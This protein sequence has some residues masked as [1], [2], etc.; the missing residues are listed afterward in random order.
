MKLAPRHVYV[1]IFPT[2]GHVAYLEAVERFTEDRRLE[3][4]GVLTG[5]GETKPNAWLPVLEVRVLEDLPDFATALRRLVSTAGHPTDEM[6]KAEY[7][8]LTVEVAH[9]VAGPVAARRIPE[10]ARSIGSRCRL[11]VIDTSVFELPMP[12]RRGWRVA[13]GRRAVAAALFEAIE[14]NRLKTEVAPEIAREAAAQVK[15]LTTR[16]DRENRTLS[17]E[18]LARTLALTVWM[19]TA[20]P[21]PKW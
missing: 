11:A 21:R 9:D 12:E 3:S 19:Q 16:P 15:A 4:A 14:E 13:V 8:N 5:R 2:P 20:Q 10:I 17:D 6:A 7:F 18:I 1:T